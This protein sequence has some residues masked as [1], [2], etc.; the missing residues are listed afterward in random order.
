MVRK[1]RQRHDASEIICEFCVKGVAVSWRAGGRRGENR[2]RLQL[3]RD[4]VAGGA[5][6]AVAGSPIFSGKVTVNIA[7]FSEQQGPD[8]DNMAKPILDAMQGI[9]Y[10]NDRQV[11]GH[12]A[13]WC[14]ID[15]FY[16]VR[17]MSRVVAAAMSEG[18]PFVWVRVLRHQP[19]SALDR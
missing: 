8:L 10:E 5:T 18:S 16:E 7:L 15:G 4:A 1:V 19:R 13:E 17:F 14:D 3:W 11:A 12:L 2:R 6:C 9:V